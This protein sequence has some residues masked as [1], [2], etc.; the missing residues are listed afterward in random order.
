MRE[1]KD[2]GSALFFLGR[3]L[4]H[5]VGANLRVVEYDDSYN[6]KNESFYLTALKGYNMETYTRRR[7]G[8]F[9]L[10]RRPT[11]TAAETPEKPYSYGY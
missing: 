7:N 1:R 6:N 8:R 9:E 11:F 10:E 4:G 5:Q 2:L 3:H